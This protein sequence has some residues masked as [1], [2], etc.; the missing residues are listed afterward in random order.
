MLAD[1]S[2]GFENSRRDIGA[3]FEIEREVG[4]FYKGWDDDV[5]IDLDDA[6]HQ[7]PTLDLGDAE[8]KVGSAGAQ[9]NETSQ[10]ILQD[11]QGAGGTPGPFTSSP[12]P[13]DSVRGR[14]SSM[15]SSPSPRTSPS[16]PVHHPIPGNR[17]R[18]NSSIHEPSPL[19]RLFVSPPPNEPSKRVRDRRQSM[20]Q[21]LSI[22]SSGSQPALLSSL[23]S[24][25]KRQHTRMRFLLPA[26]ERIAK[27][28]AHF[29]ANPS[30]STIDEGRKVSL[31]A[32]P[33]PYPAPTPVPFPVSPKKVNTA[34]IIASDASGSG[35]SRHKSP[36]SYEEVRESSIIGT[37]IGKASDVVEEMRDALPAVRD[38]EWRER[39]DKIEKTQ[40][41][42]EK[43]LSR[44]VR[45]K[46]YG[47]V[48]SD[49]ER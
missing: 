6:E 42:I 25:P 19:A 39:L 43:L 33:K 12:G 40:D 30:I 10:S 48:F 47:D 11:G 37:S 44:L 29:A 9:E 2:A 28:V 16:A 22:L 32:S 4:S 17:Q 38:E 5:D 49:D 3:V 15:P 34:T 13:V 35:L 27:K 46:G 45:D 8:D 18:R 23:L 26:P 21:S 24:P 7:L 31:P 1:W 14:R 41:R 20:M 36:A